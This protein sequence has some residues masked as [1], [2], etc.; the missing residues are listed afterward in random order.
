MRKNVLLADCKCII[1][2]KTYNYGDNI[3]NTTDG[4]GNCI[5]AECAEN[6]IV[7]RSIYP[8]FNTTTPGP[9]TTPFT[10]STILKTTSGISHFSNK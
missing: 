1:N 2:G 7:T 6:G 3:Y 9:T 5:T 8:C 10:F 4:L